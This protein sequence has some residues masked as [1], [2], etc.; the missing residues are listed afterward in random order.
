[1]SA[2]QRM[3]RTHHPGD[4]MALEDV[5]YGAHTTV[6]VR[7]A[8]APGESSSAAQTANNDAGD[9][10]SNGATT[11]AVKSLGIT[12]GVADD[13]RSAG[14][15]AHGIAVTE[16]KRGGPAEGKLLPGDIITTVI[17][18]E[19][20]TDTRTIGAFNAVINKMHDGDFIGLL[21]SRA[22]DA[23]GNRT[24]AVVNLKLAK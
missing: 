2:L 23:N 4:E 17:H 7:L 13:Q 14:A 16:V 20:R 18:P 3:V 24:T 6:K 5:R 22:V 8:E 15:T 10:T 11:M 12:V 21:I 19:P 9:M 1:M